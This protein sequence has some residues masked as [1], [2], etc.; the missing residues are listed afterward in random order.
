MYKWSVNRHMKKSLD[1]FIK[2][3]QIK[4]KIRYPLISEYG[5]YLK[6]R[7]EAQES[8]QKEGNP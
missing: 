5:F 4:T 1:S 2:K 3:M 8:L 6:D 7:K